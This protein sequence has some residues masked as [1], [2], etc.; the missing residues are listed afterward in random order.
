[1]S[2]RVAI[3][4]GAAVVAGAAKVISALRSKDDKDETDAAESGSNDT[5]HVSG[6]ESEEQRESWEAHREAQQRAPPVELGEVRKIGVEEILDH[7]TDS[8]QA[9]G[10]IEGFQIFVDDIPR[11]IRSLDF[12]RVKIMSYGRG[13]TSAQAK[14]LERA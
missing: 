2:Y 5:E 9:R 13:R 4:V 14:F 1:M 7:H 3:T 8:P 6:F 11:D 12:I 10:E